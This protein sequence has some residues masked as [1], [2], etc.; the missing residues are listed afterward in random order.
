MASIST[1]LNTISNGVYGRDIR[2][3]I[4]DAIKLVN[5]HV[6]TKDSEINEGIENASII[7]DKAILPEKMSFLTLGVNKINEKNIS[8]GFYDASG[9]WN[10]TETYAT[11][12]AKV[13]PNTTY[14]LWGGVMFQLLYFSK[15]IYNF[16]FFKKANNSGYVLGVESY[17]NTATYNTPR[18]ITTPKNCEYITLTVTV[19]NSGGIHSYKN[20]IMLVE[21]ENYPD[22]YYPYEFTVDK[23][24]APTKD[25]AAFAKYKK[26][27]ILYMG[28]SITAIKGKRSWVEYCNS[29]LE[30]ELYVNT[31]IN[32]AR[33]C[34][35]TDTIYDG[36]PASGSN[37]NTIGNQVEKILRG[38]D[39]NNENYKYVAEYSDFDIIFIA[40]GTNDSIGGITE[41]IEDVFTNGNTIVPVANVDRTTIR[42]AFRYTIEML[43]TQ[44]PNAQIFICTPIQGYITTRAYA[45]TKKIG[46]H[47]IDLAKRM[48][49][50][51][52]NTFECGICGIYE[53]SGK[54]GRDLIDGLHPNENGAVKIG[55][56]NANSI[57]Q[58]YKNFDLE[59]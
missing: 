37:N 52:I 27:K 5:A 21:G 45:N 54:N 18:T 36:A 59:V 44:Y 51:H 11:I 6:E 40:L 25:I 7:N 49:V 22:K 33:W 17:G 55:A 41:N 46:D 2:V 42:G 23:Y 15:E 26:R 14:S 50:E 56:Y 35:Y 10:D 30:P 39:T 43:Q 47:L 13:K 16:G 31:A 28:D 24:I 29:I 1:Q 3:A 12:W 19:N 38:K 9:R 48:S 57:I 20:N 32:S 8:K 58:K 34:D 4:H 53:S